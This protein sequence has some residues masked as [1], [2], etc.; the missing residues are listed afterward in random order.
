MEQYKRSN[1]VEKMITMIGR[2]KISCSGAAE[3]AR[4]AMGDGLL[5]EA[6]VAFGSLGA[7]GSSASNSERDLTRWLK[8]LFGF[9]LESYP[10]KMHLQVSCSNLSTSFG[11]GMLVYWLV[12]SLGYIGLQPIIDLS[13]VISHYTIGLAAIQ[14][15]WLVQGR[16]VHYKGSFA[17]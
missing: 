2:G 10:V 16:T 4:D 7:S 15:I 8:R 13:W 9:S 11:F 14:G 12:Q 5:H 6:V 3:L 17:S 1:F